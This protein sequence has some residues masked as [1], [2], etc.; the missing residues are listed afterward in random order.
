MYTYSD[1]LCTEWY[2][3]CQYL[4]FDACLSLSLIFLQL[5]NDLEKADRYSREAARCIMTSC[6]LP[7][8]SVSHLHHVMAL[9]KAHQSKC[10]EA[11]DHMEDAVLEREM[12]GLAIDPGL[13]RER[14]RHQ[15]H[16]AKHDKR[17]G[18]ASILAVSEAPK[19][20]LT[21]AQEIFDKACRKICCSTFKDKPSVIRTPFHD[22]KPDGLVGWYDVYCK[23]T[24]IHL[25]TMGVRADELPP[26]VDALFT[27]PECHLKAVADAAGASEASR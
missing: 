19:M 2:E 22:S 16:V 20:R 13:E 17:P 11:R 6:H 1:R 26:Y 23:L 15:A 21:F 10:H 4:R 5:G 7:P 27:K 9:V 18:G 3:A 12:A 24:P 8:E 14:K 25:K